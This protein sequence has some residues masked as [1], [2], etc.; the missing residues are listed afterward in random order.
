MCDA[1]RFARVQAHEA[2]IGGFAKRDI[3]RGEVVLREKPIVT[4]A[5]ASGLDAAIA[6][7]DDTARRKFFSL[8]DWRTPK[9]ALGIFQSNGY[10]CGDKAGVCFKFS[11]VN[12]SCAPN[13]CHVWDEDGFYYVF[14]AK[15]IRKGDE[16]C[17]TYID[18]AQPRSQRQAILRDHFGFDCRCPACE[19]P[20]SQGDDRRQRIADLDVAIYEDVKKGR[21]DAAVVKADERIRLLELEGIDTPPMMVRTC[22]DAHQAMVHKGDR[23]RAGEWFQR[24]D[25]YSKLCVPHHPHK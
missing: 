10:P 7:L 5:D 19:E 24:L 21:Y 2:G 17:T 16:L 18:V 20:S 3:V 11:R 25:F 15:D 6:A 8:C 22:N 1:I 4:V 9:T 12:H 23:R 14:A 13:L